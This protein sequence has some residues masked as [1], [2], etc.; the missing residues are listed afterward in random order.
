MVHGR[1]SRLSSAP[2][3]STCTS[4]L[5]LARDDRSEFK[6]DYRDFFLFFYFARVRIRL[7]L[8]F[9]FRCAGS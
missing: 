3:R 5:S 8:F 1:G 9:F 7:S 6:A 2:L 4:P